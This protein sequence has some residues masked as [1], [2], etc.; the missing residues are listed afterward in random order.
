MLNA[1]RSAVFA[2]CLKSAVISRDFVHCAL[3]NPIVSRL[4][5]YCALE[6]VVISRNLAHCA[7]AHFWG[8]AKKDRNLQK[9]HD[10][11]KTQKV[12]KMLWKPIAWEISE[13]EPNREKSSRMTSHYAPKPSQSSSPIAPP[14]END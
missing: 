8:K 13:S 12:N 3:K 4:V 10:I 6:N 9:D 1:L 7:L 2:L 14:R 11:W 5:V